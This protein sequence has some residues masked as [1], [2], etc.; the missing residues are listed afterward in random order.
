[1]RTQ[2]AIIDAGP[3]GLFH[4]GSLGIQ[5]DCLDDAAYCR[6]HSPNSG[7]PIHDGRADGD[8]IELAGSHLDSCR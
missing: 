3:P 7:V 1:M 4:T 6:P 8:A 2:V 5:R